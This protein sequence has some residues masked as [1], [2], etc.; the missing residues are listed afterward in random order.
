[1]KLYAVPAKE[2]IFEQGKPGQY[3]YVVI[4]GSLEVSIEGTKKAILV[5]GDTFGE[6]ALIHN[7]PRSATIRTL[8][9]CDLWVLD[10]KTFQAVLEQMNSQRYSENMNFIESIPLLRVLT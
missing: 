3:F 1:M 7:S 2:V 9:I 4:S 5:K 10:R 8:S 6:L